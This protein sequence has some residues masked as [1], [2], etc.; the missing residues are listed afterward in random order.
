MIVSLCCIAISIASLDLFFLQAMIAWLI[1]SK[2]RL[3]LFLGS[4]PTFSDSLSFTSADVLDVLDCFNELLIASK[5]Y[6]FSFELEQRFSSISLY[7]SLSFALFLASKRESLIM[8]MKKFIQRIV[9]VKRIR[10]ANI[11]ASIV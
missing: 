6:F 1:K 4:R 8:P 7:S 11:L 9:R 5:N 3:E 2:L 10:K